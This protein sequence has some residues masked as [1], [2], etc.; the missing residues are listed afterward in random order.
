MTVVDAVHIEQHLDKELPEGAC[1]E[2]AEQ[3]AFADIVLL[4]K[5]DLLKVG[6]TRDSVQDAGHSAATP[7]QFLCISPVILLGAALAL[8]PRNGASTPSELHYAVE[9]RFIR[10]QLAFWRLMLGRK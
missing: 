3:L 7:G 10:C 9:E 8:M 6:G 4:N 5:C 1:C 2:S